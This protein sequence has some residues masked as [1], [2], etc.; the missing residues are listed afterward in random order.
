MLALRAG[1]GQDGFARDKQ[2]R[3]VVITARTDDSE[4][5]ICMFHWPS[6]P[7]IGVWLSRRTGGSHPLSSV[8]Q[9]SGRAP[10]LHSRPAQEGGLRPPH[11]SSTAQTFS[12]LA[13]G[14]GF[15]QRQRQYQLRLLARFRRTG[16]FQ[17]RRSDILGFREFAFEKR[18]NGCMP[19]WGVS[20]SW[21][22]RFGEIVKLWW[23]RL[24]QQRERAIELHRATCACHRHD[25]QAP[26]CP[27]GRT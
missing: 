7:S 20:Q 13:E 24:E 10:L 22:E 2:L 27:V 17:L 26:G 9:A 3:P 4:D 15:S 25:S 14:V 8:D 21:D 23:A 11:A 12:L 16:L 19:R 6:P 18:L 1:N 5:W